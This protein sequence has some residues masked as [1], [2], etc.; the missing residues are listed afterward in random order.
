MRNSLLALAGVA[1]FGL[2]A[3]VATPAAAEEKVIV[4]E[5]RDHPVYSHREYYGR[6]FHRD[7]DH[8][9]VIIKKHDRD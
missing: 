4:K 7:H 3:P 8:K 6:S 5:H 9:T 2:V 1:V